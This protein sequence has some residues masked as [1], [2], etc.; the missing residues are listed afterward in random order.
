MK[1]TILLLV[2]LGV[3]VSGQGIWLTSGRTHPEL[4]WSTISSEHFNIHYHQGLEAIAEKALSIAEQSRPTL[5]EQVG[6][7]DLPKIDI[8]LT[9]E[10]EVMNGYAMWSNTIFIWV[11]QNDAA[12]WLEDQKWLYQVMTHELQ[13]VVFFNALASPWLPEPWNY[14]VSGTPGWFV[15]GLAEYMTEHWRPYRADLSHKIHILRNNVQE[16]NPHHDGYS[17]LLYLAD[18]FSDST[19]VKIIQYRTKLKTA[20][21]KK[22]FKKYTGISVKQFNEDWRRQMNTYYYG[23]RAQKETI[24]EVGQVV[25]LPMKEQ[26]GFAV[27]PDSMRIAIVSRLDKDHLDQSLVIATRD[28]SKKKPGGLE[29]LLGKFKKKADEKPKKSPLVWKTEEID[30]G[31]IQGTL[32][33]SPDGKKV[34]YAKYHYGVR[35]SLVWDLRVA[36]FSGKKP[37]F[38][39]ITHSGR[40]LHPDWSPDGK[41]L[42][43]V[44]HNRNVSNLITVDNGRPGDGCA[45]YL[46]SFH[47]RHANS[48]APLESGR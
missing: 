12:L 22:G 48:H 19:I 26:Y 24:E 47:G 46:N 9:A 33:W 27:S 36:D 41:R 7:T 6:L 42:V 39:W 30:Y 20:N 32:S 18:R 10:D 25:S 4:R 3:Y 14:A 2:W 16:M 40:A 37:E 35:Q 8:T 38:H 13:H 45:G 28:T 11:D 15:E 44:L 29:K 17:K 31:R 34:A 1:K 43:Y 5:M 21:F 23:Y